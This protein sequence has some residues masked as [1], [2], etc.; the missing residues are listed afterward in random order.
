MSLLVCYLLVLVILVQLFNCLFVC[1]FSIETVE[2][3]YDVKSSTSSEDSL[4]ADTV[5]ESSSQPSWSEHLRNEMRKNFLKNNK[6]TSASKQPIE[7]KNEDVDENETTSQSE[8]SS[9]ESLIQDGDGKDFP[10]VNK[11]KST[12]IEANKMPPSLPLGESN[13]EGLW[14]FSGDN[15]PDHDEDGGFLSDSRQG[16]VFISLLVK[17]VFPLY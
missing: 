5:S 11:A 8:F 9:V 3:E 10:K 7:S 17:N 12:A 2:P 14:K 13:P 15:E 6:D 1:L 16:S 4:A